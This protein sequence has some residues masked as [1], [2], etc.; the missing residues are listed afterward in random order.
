MFYQTH[1][2]EWCEMSLSRKIATV[3]LSLASIR[4]AM[5]D[6]HLCSDYKF[7]ED[8]KSS[9]WQIQQ[10]MDDLKGQATEAELREAREITNAPI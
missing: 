7:I 9:E 6:A 8:N 10:E 2:E 1:R 4:K 5:A 3:A